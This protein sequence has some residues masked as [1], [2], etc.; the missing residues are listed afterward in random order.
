MVKANFSAHYKFLSYKDKNCRILKHHVKWD[1]DILLFYAKKGLY[2]IVLR[3]N[4]IIFERYDNSV[5]YKLVGKPNYRLLLYIKEYL[6][7]KE[8]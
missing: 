8:K 4:T 5:F 1:L 3:S 2:N 7:K 6:E